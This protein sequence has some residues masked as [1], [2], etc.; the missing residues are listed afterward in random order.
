MLLCPQERLIENAYAGVVYGSE[1]CSAVFAVASVASLVDFSNCLS[2]T[3]WTVFFPPRPALH[4]RMREGEI[5]GASRPLEIVSDCGSSVDR[6]RSCMHI[7]NLCLL[8]FPFFA[9][10]RYL[11]PCTS[12]RA[13]AHLLLLCCSP[14][15]LL[16]TFLSSRPP[17]RYPFFSPT[18]IFEAVAQ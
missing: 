3:K 5:V 11:D 4:Y 1:I 15:L 18:A 9:T 2:L 17:C 6:H 8:C 10:C 16:V 13:R 7:S 14:F 12:V